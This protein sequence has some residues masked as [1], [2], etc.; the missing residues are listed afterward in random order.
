MNFGEREGRASRSGFRKVLLFFN[1]V[2]AW[3]TVGVAKVS[4][5][6]VYI[7]K[8]VNLHPLPSNSTWSLT[9]QLCQFSS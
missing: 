9:Y 3:K 7:D 5:L 2:L 4:V 1:I 6:Y 8:R